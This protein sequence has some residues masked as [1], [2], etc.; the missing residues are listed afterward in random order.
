MIK[1]EN[2]EVAELDN[3]V[4]RRHLLAEPVDIGPSFVIGSRGQGKTTLLIKEA[5]ETNGVI[6][7]PTSM[8]ANH[9]FFRAQKLGYSINRPITYDEMFKNSRGKRNDYYF[10]EFGHQLTLVLR[11]WINN[12]T[13][14][15]IKTVII[16]NGSIASL[17]D[18]LSGMNV[19][20][21]DGAKLR[22]KIKVCREEDDDCI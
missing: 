17:N 22:L 4:L 5:S 14:D 7:C 6:I 11:R 9:I 19:R 2:I 1:I 8:M 3:D 15:R 18:I 13:H 21:M 16:D 10:D 12:L 20:D